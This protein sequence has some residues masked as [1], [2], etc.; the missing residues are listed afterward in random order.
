MITFCNKS[1]CWIQ[2]HMPIAKKKKTF[3]PEFVAAIKTERP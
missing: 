2:K 3:S 1:H